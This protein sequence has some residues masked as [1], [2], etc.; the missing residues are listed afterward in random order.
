MF[1][2]ETSPMGNVSSVLQLSGQPL[3]RMLHQ[4]V[5]VV[6]SRFALAIEDHLLYAGLQQPPSSMMS[7]VPFSPESFPS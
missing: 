1:L 4:G 7:S 5:C 6:F 2:E 3:Y